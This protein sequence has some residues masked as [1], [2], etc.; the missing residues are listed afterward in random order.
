MQ[1]STLE[2]GRWFE[3]SLNEQMGNI[4][5]EIGRVLRARKQNNP[6]AL[7]NA[8]DRALELIDLTIAD[9]NRKH[10]LKEIIRARE[11]FIDSL[12]TKK[13]YRSDLVSIDKY[14]M[15]FAIASRLNR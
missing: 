8:R 12:A 7:E 5:T 3:L 13:A 4:G 15:H 1:H 2:N 10:Q 9:P 14:F 6:I 11:V